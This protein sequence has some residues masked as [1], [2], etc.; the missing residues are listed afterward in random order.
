MLI[1]YYASLAIIA[2]GAVVMAVG[3]VFAGRYWA[4]N[5]EPPQSEE[6]EQRRNWMGTMALSLV[7]I[8]VLGC[9]VG[10]LFM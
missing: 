7:I 8:G 6:E 10:V 9:G 3:L 2:L 4:A 1:F 5:R